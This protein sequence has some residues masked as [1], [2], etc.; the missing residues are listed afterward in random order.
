MQYN[1]D[2]LTDMICE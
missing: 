1:K 2:L